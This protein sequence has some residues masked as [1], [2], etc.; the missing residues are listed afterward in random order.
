MH[1][2]VD[3]ILTA[4][5][6]SG[7]SP[8]C[9]NTTPPKHRHGLSIP[10]RQVCG[11]LP[12]T[13]GAFPLRVLALIEWPHES[14]TSSS[15][16]PTFPPGPFFSIVT[17]PVSTSVNVWL[18]YRF[19]QLMSGGETSKACTSTPRFR[20]SAAQYPVPAS[21]STSTLF[22]AFTSPAISESASSEGTANAK[23]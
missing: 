2:R 22:S 10:W 14:L 1:I 8:T 23:V 15:T 4:R 9:T 11:S 6:L 17:P 7:S 13:L 5:G 12:R 3:I 18:K 16:F 20:K 21:S 19:P